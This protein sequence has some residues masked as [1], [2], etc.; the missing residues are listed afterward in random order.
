MSGE[1][2]IVNVWDGNERRRWPRVLACSSARIRRIKPPLPL[3]QHVYTKDLSSFGACFFITDS[4]VFKTNDEVRVVFVIRSNTS[5]I[6]V[7]Y[8]LCRVAWSH[9]GRVGVEFLFDDKGVP[10]T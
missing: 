3:L 10:L 9:M 4:I 6:R 1:K 7:H 8:R 5:L 2:I